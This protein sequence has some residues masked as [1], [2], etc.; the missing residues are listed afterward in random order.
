MKQIAASMAQELT[1]SSIVEFQQANAAQSERLARM[2]YP[3]YDEVMKFLPDVLRSQKMVEAI[4]SD[5]DPA[6]LAYAL[7]KTNPEYVK[8]VAA[9]QTQQVAQKIQENLSA[10]PSI[11]SAPAAVT[12]QQ[13]PQ[14]EA[15]RIRRMSDAE[16]DAYVRSKRGY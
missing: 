2:I 6:G 12:K 13:T 8:T 15:E 10:Q 7:A 16:F 4:R 3:D 5:P 9:K 11:A 1:Q 14:D